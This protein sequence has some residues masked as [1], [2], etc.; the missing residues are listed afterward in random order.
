M[1]NWIEDVLFSQLPSELEYKP[2]R[3]KLSKIIEAMEFITEYFIKEGRKFFKFMSLTTF[4]V[5]LFEALYGENG[6]DKFF[7]EL[8]QYKKFD[9]KL[10]YYIFKG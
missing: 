8:N 7:L 5:R 2:L 1:E 4:F 6:K 10:R 3:E 9:S